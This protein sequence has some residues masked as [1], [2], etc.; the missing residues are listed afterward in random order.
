M[1]R[2][3]RFYETQQSERS[4]CPRDPPQKCLGKKKKANEKTNTQKI[5]YIFTSDDDQILDLQKCMYITISFTSRMYNSN[6]FQEAHFPHSVRNYHTRQNTNSVIHKFQESLTTFLF[7]S[8]ETHLQTPDS[9]PRETMTREE[10]WYT[11]ICA[12]KWFT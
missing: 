11:E 5:E 2:H 10:R 3:Q 1:R 7:P 4:D 8:H 6:R 9:A 12:W